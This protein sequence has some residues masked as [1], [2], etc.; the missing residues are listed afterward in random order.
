M[1]SLDT[2]RNS[3]I[4]TANSSPVNNVTIP[5]HCRVKV[6]HDDGSNEFGAYRRCQIAEAQFC[7]QPADSILMSDF[8]TLP[9]SS[10]DNNT[11]QRPGTATFARN[12]SHEPA[13]N[14]G[15]HYDRSSF[16]SS[17]IGGPR[18]LLGGRMLQLSEP[19]STMRADNAYGNQRQGHGKTFSYHPQVSTSIQA[20]D[21]GRGGSSYAPWQ[22]K[23]ETN[24]RRSPAT[25]SGNKYDNDSTFSLDSHPSMGFSDATRTISNVGHTHDTFISQPEAQDTDQIHEYGGI[26]LSGNTHSQSAELR[27]LRDDEQNMEDIDGNSDNYD[28]E[29]TSRDIGSNSDIEY[30]PRPKILT[31]GAPMS[32]SNHFSGHFERAVYQVRKPQQ[33]VKKAHPKRAKGATDPENT[34]IVDL[35]DNHNWQFSAIAQ[36]LNIE[37]EKKGLMG[38]FTPNSVHNRYNRSA[39]IIYK[40]DGRVFVAI[41]DRRHHTQDELDS[42]SGGVHT[43]VWNKQMDQVLKRVVAD[44]DGDKWRRVAEVF[45]AI[46]KQ[47]LHA[48]TISARF[49]LLGN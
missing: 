42:L 40:A 12:Q 32:N 16:P 23:V 6:G 30:S 47:N 22:G 13:Q 48:S 33:K 28:N 38:R 7:N 8:Q 43:T 21:I 27:T 35:Y 15:N 44:Y 4:N 2:C 25:N 5:E 49:G 9:T 10:L 45:N 41:K 3:P 37:R 11:N 17:A 46:T 24:F 29:P 20:F 18:S 36:Y 19:E 31:P 1:G 34:Q 26:Q 14:R 39:P